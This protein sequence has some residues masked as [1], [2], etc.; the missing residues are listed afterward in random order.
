M[1]RRKFLKISFGS[2]TTAAAGGICR[3]M[4]SI[5]NR[6]RL[7]TN[8]LLITSEDNGPQLGCYGNDSVDTPNLD[9]LAAQGVRFENAFVTQASCSPSRSS[10]LTGLYPHQN[11]QI[12]LATH[13]YRM[14][15]EFASI[16]SVL[17]NAG[18]RTGIIGKLHVKPKSAFDFEFERIGLNPKTFSERDVGRFAALAGGFFEASPEPFFLMVNYPDA[19]HPFIRQ[20]YGLPKKPLEAED[21]KPLEF[22][23]YDTVGLRGVTANYYN[24]IKRLDAGIGM[25]LDKLKKSGKAENTLVIYVGDHGPD[26]PRAKT[27]VYEAALKVPLVIRLPGEAETGTVR[28]ELVSTV[29]IMPTVLEAAG[30]ETIQGLAGN[31]LMPLLKG[32]QTNWRKYICAENHAHSA[33][34]YFPQRS[35][36]DGR[37]KLI[38]NLLAGRV[39]PSVSCQWRPVKEFDFG[40]QIPGKVDDKVRKAYQRF[41]KPPARELYDLRKDPCEFENLA[42]DEK[43]NEILE[44]LLHE[45]RKWQQQTHDPLAD[46]Q[47]LAALTAEHDRLAEKGEMKKNFV[48]N[49]PQYLFRD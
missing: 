18:Y 3:A 46:K 39:N 4:A 28:N 24:C 40:G 26:M 34:I 19:H 20:Q 37:Y 29:D 31:S 41:R 14:Y 17:K 13:R 45:L 38:V 47:K 48:W 25:L 10:I 16:P 9:A 6:N 32:R 33:L 5:N 2:I 7:K 36:S 1:K 35:I 12:G 11:G 49:Y 43:Y 8:V 23:G 22:V 30:I 21:V 42:G 44:R 15:R 27:T